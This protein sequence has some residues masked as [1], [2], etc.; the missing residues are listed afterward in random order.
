[1]SAIAP[2]SRRKTR[3]GLGWPTFMDAKE[4]GKRVRAARAYGGWTRAEDLAEAVGMGRTTLLR[5]EKGER[6]AKHWELVAIAEL[7]GLPRS[8]FTDEWDERDL[9]AEVDVRALEAA[10]EV[11]V[12]L[13]AERGPDAE[14]AERRRSQRES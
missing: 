8:F 11:A 9:P 7:C 1:M 2:L 10:E 4:I 13:A 12:E 14:Q 3:I 6:T 5:T